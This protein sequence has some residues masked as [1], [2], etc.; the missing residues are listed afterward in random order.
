MTANRNSLLRLDENGIPILEE[1][2]E[3]PP[4]DDLAAA[5]KA[6]LLAELEPQL[7]NMV[8]NAMTESIKAGALE[9]KRSFEQHLDR[10]L[11]IR[12]HELVEQAVERACR[13]TER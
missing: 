11:E 4:L 8:H 9:L 3:P 1:V 7:L 12:V 5:I 10:S 6:Q 2:L 13:E